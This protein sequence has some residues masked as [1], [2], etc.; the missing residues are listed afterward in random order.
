[1]KKVGQRYQ[2]AVELAATRLA[3]RS[4]DTLC[5]LPALSS[6][7]FE[8]EIG[9]LFCGISHISPNEHYPLHSF[10]LIFD[11]SFFLGLY[12]RYLA[13]FSLGQQKQVLPIPTELLEAED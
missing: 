8:T 13:G 2:M 3:T 6:E 4:Y 10:V 11:R 7:T 9:D 1:M 5:G 12:K